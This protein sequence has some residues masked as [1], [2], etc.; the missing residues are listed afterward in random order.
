[1]NFVSIGKIL[2]LLLQFTG[3]VPLDPMYEGLMD[4]PEEWNCIRSIEGSSYSFC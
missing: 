2:H 1:M 4:S 3:N